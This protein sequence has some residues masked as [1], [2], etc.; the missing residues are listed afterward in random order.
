[1]NMEENNLQNN[2]EPIQNNTDSSERR[3]DEPSILKFEK[4]I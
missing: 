3:S 4:G 1:M 2:C